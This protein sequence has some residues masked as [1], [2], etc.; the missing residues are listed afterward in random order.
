MAAA[1]GGL[2][3]SVWDA[4]LIRLFYITSAKNRSGGQ[5]SES[6]PRSSFEAE[7]LAPWTGYFICKGVTATD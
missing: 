2:N 3:A 7:S 4:Y 6:L 1:A 5:E